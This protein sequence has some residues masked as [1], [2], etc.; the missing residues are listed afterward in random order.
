MRGII[1]I[2][3]LHLLSIYGNSQ[4]VTIAS[5]QSTTRYFQASNGSMTFPVE[6]TLNYNGDGVTV[7]DTVAFE[8][9]NSTSTALV[10]NGAITTTVIFTADEFEKKVKE[11]KVMINITM[12]AV[13]QLDNS[14]LFDIQ[15][16][17]SSATDQK[18]RVIVENIPIGQPVSTAQISHIITDTAFQAPLERDEAA[19]EIRNKWIKFQVTGILDKDS[20]IELDLTGNSGNNITTELETKTF[21]ILRSKTLTGNYIDSVRVYYKVNSVKSFGKDETAFIKFK[22]GNERDVLVFSRSRLVH[23]NKPFWI[24]LG[25][26]FDLIDGVIPNNLFAGVFFYKRDIRSFTG[27]KHERVKSY[28]VKSETQDVPGQT[29]FEKKFVAGQKYIAKEKEINIGILS[30]IYQSR[31]ISSESVSTLVE[32]QDGRSL[33][34]DTNNRF[35]VFR[36]TGNI[37][38]STTINN[39]GLFFSPQL[40]WTSRS[41]NMDGL[42]GFFSIWIE[43]VWQKSE[44]VYDYTKTSNLDTLRITEDLIPQYTHKLTKTNL[45]FRTQYYG[46]GAPFFLKEGDL[47]LFF[48]PVIGVTNQRFYLPDVSEQLATS[49]GKPGLSKPLGSLGHEWSAFFLTTFRLSEEKYGISFTGEV[50]GLVGRQA[51]P[52]ISLALSKKF[53]LTKLLEYK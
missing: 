37:L 19:S 30:G 51:K 8:V 3:I 38:Q 29:V 44:T 52:I 18:H 10:A 20:T 14:E 27:H 48:N 12:N 9:V 43:M 35:P 53:D 49:G 15:I 36:D 26:N 47:N 34:A 6:V 4:I 41:A 24:E 45:D 25:S 13:S 23:M 21:R 17:G 28:M 22:N 42:H 1:L 32:Y 11:K 31:S 7:P 16:A 33:I 2:V 46:V 39:L 5:K 40:R 50:R